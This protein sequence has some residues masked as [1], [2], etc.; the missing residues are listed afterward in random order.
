MDTVIQAFMVFAA[1]SAL[2]E[3]VI[4][5]VRTLAKDSNRP[6]WVNFIDAITIGAWSWLWAVG[7]A[8]ATHADALQLFGKDPTFFDNVMKWSD[9][10]IR[11]WAGCI[12]MG[13]SA[14]LGSRFWHDF[15]FGLMDV[16]DRA[17]ALPGAAAGGQNKA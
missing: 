10:G 14:T 13:F 9:F 17:K 11:S 2:V 15:A 16:R 7:I 6:R 4:E 8:L 12:L 5:L 1:F 3:R